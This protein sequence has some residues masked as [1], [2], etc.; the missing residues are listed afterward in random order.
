MGVQGDKIPA[1][2]AGVP[3]PVLRKSSVNYYG[4]VDFHDIEIRR[5]V[6]CVERTSSIDYFVSLFV[7]LFVCL[8]VCVFVCLS[9]CQSVR[10]CLSHGS[11]SVC[12]SALRV[13]DMRTY[14]W[15]QF[16]LITLTRNFLAPT[17]NHQPLI[18]PENYG[19]IFLYWQIGN[20]VKW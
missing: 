5:V 16:S 17:D 11:L 3:T 9:V 20:L 10:I 7:C 15:Q 13:H 18:C 12:L 14:Q 1:D 8:S 6:K 4:V 19:A 2:L